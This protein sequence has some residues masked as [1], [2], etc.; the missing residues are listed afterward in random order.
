[1]AELEIHTE[2]EHQADPR[3]QKVGILAAVL[4]VGLAMVTIASHRAHTTGVLLRTEANDHWAH[5]QSQR[6]KLHNLELGE[7]LIRLLGSRNEATDRAL[8]RYKNEKDRYEGESKK[9]QDEARQKEIEGDAVEQRA[10]RYDFGEGLLEIALVLTSLYFISRKMLF[11][12]IGIIA[13]VAGVIIAI[14]GFVV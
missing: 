6:L 14:T 2:S 1:M 13:G 12:V 10:L 5:Y 8:E 11:P 9:V 7:D 3:G 4:A